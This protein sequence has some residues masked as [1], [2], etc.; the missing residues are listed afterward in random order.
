MTGIIMNTI[1]VMEIMIITT[2]MAMGTAKRIGLFR[3][4]QTMP[5]KKP[6]VKI[7]PGDTD[8]AKKF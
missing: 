2:S 5:P 1:T 4:E 8:S 7:K 3:M 6:L